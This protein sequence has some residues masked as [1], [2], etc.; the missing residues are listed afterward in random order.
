MRTG[1]GGGD[2]DEEERADIHLRRLLGV[3]R[4]VRRDWER[5]RLVVLSEVEH[6]Q[7]I[8]KLGSRMYSRTVGSLSRKPADKSRVPAGRRAGHRRRGAESHGTDYGAN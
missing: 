5:A 8:F 6:L 4:T 1:G 2:A 7:V 3:A